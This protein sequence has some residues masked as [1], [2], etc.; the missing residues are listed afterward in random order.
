MVHYVPG[1]GIKAFTLEARLGKGTSGEVWSASDG[2][3]KVALKLLKPELVH[4]SNLPHLRQRQLQEA[5]ALR[6]LEQ[7]PHLPVLYNWDL[8]YDHPF[9]AMQL[10]EGDSYDRLIRAGKLLQ[11]PL[12]QRLHII[13]VLADTLETLHEAQLLHRDI[14]PANVV[15]IDQPLLLDYRISLDEDQ[16]DWSE[17]NIKSWPYHPYDG[18]RD[19]LGDIYSFGLLSY[20]ILLGHHAIFE[21]ADLRSISSASHAAADVAAE[22]LETGQWRAPSRLPLVDLPP[23]LRSSHSEM[24]DFVFL[25]VLGKRDQ[26]YQSARTFVAALDSVIKSEAGLAD[27]GQFEGP[28]LAEEGAF[29]GKDLPIH[30]RRE[31]SASRFSTVPESPLGPPQPVAAQPPARRSLRNVAPVEIAEDQYFV[32]EEPPSARGGGP[33]LTI[34]IA[35]AIIVVLFALSFL[36]FG[37]N[38]GA[39]PT[40]SPSSTTLAALVLVE[41]PTATATLLP[42]SATVVTVATLVPTRIPSTA[43][44]SVTHS[45]TPTATLSSTPRPSPTLTLTATHIPTNTPLPTHTA[46]PFPTNTPLLPEAYE[47]SEDLVENLLTLRLAINTTPYGCSIFNR[48]YEHIQT[49]TNSTDPD[50]NEYLLY[51]PL[52]IDAMNGIR[53]SHCQPDAGTPGPLPESLAEINSSLDLLLWEIVLE[54][55]ASF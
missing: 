25:K 23:D 40:P 46:S 2:A 3:F 15:G 34:G 9:L 32:P 35:L 55:R 53:Q 45:P 20:E 13:R 50:H 4:A 27:E 49:R 48:L 26:R 11:L 52:I 39:D 17:L 18:Q 51:G 41:S 28:L 38:T 5:E 12:A 14:K 36:A 30:R 22:R 33:L 8:D 29:E 43:T 31:R 44:P 42:P 19:Q 37:N 16:I 47:P 6:R 24:L 54:I 7:Y 10:I 1:L 21:P